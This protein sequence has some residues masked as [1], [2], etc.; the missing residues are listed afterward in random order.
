MAGSAPFVLTVTGSGFLPGAF[1]L[2]NGSPDPIGV[3]A[4]TPTQ[5]QTAIPLSD[6]VTAGSITISVANPEPAVGP[7]N[8][9]TFAVTPITSNPV[10]AL[11]SALDPSVPA[12]W[13]G[14]RLHVRGSNFVAAS[15]L[16]WNGVDRPTAVISSTELAGAIPAD[17]L[18]S[19]GMAQVSVRNPSP[20]GGG[21]GTLPI[22]IKSVSSDATGVIERSDI[23][24][25]LTEADGIS[26]FAVVSGDGRFVA[27]VSSADNLGASSSEPENLFLRDT[28]IGAPTGCVPS[29]TFIFPVI[30][31]FAAKPAI[32][33]NGRFVAFNTDT[34]ILLY[35]SCGGAPSNCV[36]STR[37]VDDQ[38]NGE[39]GQIALS[40]DGRFAAFFSG[41][42]NCPYLDVCS[43]TG[44]FFLA[45][46]C[47]GT[48]SSC[49][50]SS[51]AVSPLTG[52]IVETGDG[53]GN[54]DI[55][56]P[57]ISPDG[58]FIALNINNTQLALY[59]SCQGAGASCSTSTT[60]ISVAGDA[61]P[62][63]GMSQRP[64]PSAD[65][66]YVAF[67]SSASNLVAGNVTP[68]IYRVYVRDM[69]T[70]APLGCT[71]ATTLIAVAGDGT[72]EVS[73]PSISADGRYVA[74][75][76]GAT[77]LVPGDTNG[78]EDIFVL[79]T[80]AGVSTGCLPS[81]LR[82]SVALDGTQAM[83]VLIWS[84]D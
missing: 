4:S 26:Q 24:N 21:S 14:F 70:G 78:A 29:L 6:L 76:S 18:A 47:A 71:P 72:E 77:D 19:P 60:M 64:S 59:D 61:G 25:D 45:D 66:R 46:T 28:C 20:G 63:D 39:D 15:V 16:Q 5:L 84:N 3:A 48:T 68:G 27:F 50:P 10:P 17:Q 33:A 42:F 69:C 30:F 75:M 81:T 55:V 36:P 83:K 7:S 74:Y 9:I 1:A 23:G 37:T 54:L 80:C 52:A 11:T 62:A 43:E 67:L 12:G 56:H 65:G 38:S 34:G 58:R 2:S 41:D 31:P 35:D 32:S 53:N 40:A 73:D 8:Q 82:V 79:D 13:P 49:T 51:Q 22:Q 57:S 44:Q